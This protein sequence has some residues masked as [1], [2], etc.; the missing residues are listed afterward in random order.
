MGMDDLTPQEE[1][2]IKRIEASGD[3]DHLIYGLSLLV[4]CFIIIGIGAWLSK[5][6]IVVAAALPYCIFRIL[7]LARQDKMTAGLR[8]AVEKLR[9]K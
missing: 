5:P 1:K 7:T 4:P 8:S 9:K 3:R 6:E 2:I